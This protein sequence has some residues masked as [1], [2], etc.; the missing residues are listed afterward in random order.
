MRSTRKFSSKACA[1]LPLSVGTYPCL[2]CEILCLLCLVS[3]VFSEN[4]SAISIESKSFSMPHTDIFM[5]GMS[6][7]LPFEA[8]TNMS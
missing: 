1:L 4:V 8:C 5:G 7:K 6:L 3:H 2:D